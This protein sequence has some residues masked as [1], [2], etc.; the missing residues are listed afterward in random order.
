MYSYIV[1]LQLK[2]NLNQPLTKLFKLTDKGKEID[3]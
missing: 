2:I 1:N 3:I